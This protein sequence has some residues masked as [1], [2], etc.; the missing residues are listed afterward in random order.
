MKKTSPKEK[1]EV[2]YICKKRFS[3]DD[4]SKKYK[5]RDHCHY[6]GKY[7]RAAHYI[8]N[9]RYKTPKEIPAVFDNGSTYD[10]YFTI[11]ELA[12]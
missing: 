12:K 5:V 7:R 11:K 1:Q 4:D 3:T 9:L 2:C 6:T 10:Y 8:C